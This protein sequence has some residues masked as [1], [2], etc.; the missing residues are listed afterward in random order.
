MRLYLRKLNPRSSGLKQT[1]DLPGIKMRDAD[2]DWQSAASPG[3]NHVP[4][5]GFGDLRMLKITDSEVESRKREDLYHFAPSELYECAKD[6][7]RAHFLSELN[8]VARH[9][10]QNESYCTANTEDHELGR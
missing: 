4:C 10:V 9:G 7:T 2:D 8:S 1:V 5:L 3:G 6:G